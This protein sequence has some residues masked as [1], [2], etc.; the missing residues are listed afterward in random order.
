M[1]PRLVRILIFLLVPLAGSGAPAAE[2]HSFKLMQLK[3]ILRPFLGT[4]YPRLDLIASD[5]SKLEEVT[6]LDLRDIG[7]R[8][9]LTYD[10]W[11]DGEAVRLLQLPI[12]ELAEGQ[13]GN[14]FLWILGAKEQRFGNGHYNSGDGLAITPLATVGGNLIWVKQKGVKLKRLKTALFPFDYLEDIHLAARVFNTYV[15]AG[16]VRV[17][18][19][20]NGDYAAKTDCTMSLL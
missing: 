11:I 10:A 16:E 12:A 7:G 3:K 18:D 8:E 19:F 20:I 4:Y 6:R 9:F 15:G 17:T 14:S 13:G 5:Y 2:I 1:I